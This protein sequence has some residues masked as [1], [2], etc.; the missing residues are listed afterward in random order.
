[1][2]CIIKRGNSSLGHFHLFISVLNSFIPQRTENVF[3]ADQLNPSNRFQHTRLKG[4]WMNAAWQCILFLKIEL[5]SPTCKIKPWQ[6]AKKVGTHI[7]NLALSENSLFF[8][9]PVMV[10]YIQ[11]SRLG[12]FKRK[13]YFLCPIVK[14]EKHQM[15]KVRRWLYVNDPKHLM[16]MTHIAD[17][18]WLY[19]RS[20]KF[21]NELWVSQATFPQT[22]AGLWSGKS[23]WFYC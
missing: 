15:W 22:L 16:G 2:I 21:P 10:R 3:P 9:N 18:L 1:M 19:F 6:N 8:Q 20:S 5:W 11:C 7:G 23:E 14:A 13:S 12:N 4:P 17:Y